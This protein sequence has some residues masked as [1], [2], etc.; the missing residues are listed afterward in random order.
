MARIINII[1]DV[2]KECPLTKE[3]I[4]AI[5]AELYY[6]NSTNHCINPSHPSW[7]MGLNQWQCDQIN[8]HKEDYKAWLEKELKELNDGDTFKD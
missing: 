1:K 7:W 4:N 6:V 8:S 5:K 3:E 2:H